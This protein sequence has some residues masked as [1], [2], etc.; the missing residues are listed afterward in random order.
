MSLILY[1]LSK[2][3]KDLSGKDLSNFAVL[4]VN[5]FGRQ[6]NSTETLPPD[7]AATEEDRGSALLIP[8]VIV[9]V[10]L[11]GILAALVVVVILYQKKRKQTTVAPDDKSGRDCLI[12]CVG[13][14][15]GLMI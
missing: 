8:L 15:C 10:L 3:K 14:C 13:I 6:V 4:S 2:V 7:G 12:S 11:V 1:H 9:G 5:I